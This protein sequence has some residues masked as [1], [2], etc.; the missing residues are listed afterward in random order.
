MRTGEREVDGQK[1]CLLQYPCLNDRK[2]NMI[3]KRQSSLMN[4]RK[5]PVGRKA[6]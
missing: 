6:M 4:L 1:G 5:T 2:I 3:S